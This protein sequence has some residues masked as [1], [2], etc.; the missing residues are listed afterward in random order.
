MTQRNEDVFWEKVFKIQSP[1]EK[2]GT[3]LSVVVKSALVLAQNNNDT[4]RSLFG[5]CADC[6]PRKSFTW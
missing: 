1:L 3:N 4:E 6:H 2:R 5:E